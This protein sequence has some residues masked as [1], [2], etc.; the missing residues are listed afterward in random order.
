LVTRVLSVGE[1][2]REDDSGAG[3]LLHSA[4]DAGRSARGTMR[5][6]DVA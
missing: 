4:L 3:S 5:V 1:I 6:G 2:G